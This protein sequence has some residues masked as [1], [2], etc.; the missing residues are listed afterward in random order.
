[1][2][3]AQQLV[4][5]DLSEEQNNAMMAIQSTTTVV[6]QHAKLKDVTQHVIVQDT[7]YLE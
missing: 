7:A 3:L 1:M 2:V 6:R 5:T 4:E